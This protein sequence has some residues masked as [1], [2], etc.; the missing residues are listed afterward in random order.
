M[1]DK[2]ETVGVSTVDGKHVVV[3]FGTD[4]EIIYV[5]QTLTDAAD[6]VNH[7]IFDIPIEATPA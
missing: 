1:Y 7:I 2:Q 3:D 6:C 5:C 4:D